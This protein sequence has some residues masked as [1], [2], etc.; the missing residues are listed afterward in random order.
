MKVT[1]IPIV[2]GAFSVFHRRLSDRKTP[3]V[4]RTILS[5]LVNLNNA[6][7]WMVS[8]SPSI[9]I[10]IIIIPCEFFLT[11]VIISHL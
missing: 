11:G 8:A 10:I 2:I 5:I 1:M 9:I 7:V 6:I 3:Q 4:S